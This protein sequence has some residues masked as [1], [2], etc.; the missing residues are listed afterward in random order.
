MPGR[1]VREAVVLAAGEGTR[2]R[3]LTYGRPKVLIPTANRAFL[4]HQLDLL[5]DVGINR[6]VLVVGYMK[7]MVAEW[8]SRN[9]RDGLEIIL[10]IQKEQRGTGDAVNAARG[11]VEGPFLALNGDVL[12]DR[13][14]LRK[15][16]RAECTSVAA[17][18]VANPRDYGVFE[19]EGR[20]VRRVVEKAENPPSDL[21]NVG[22]YVF[23]PDIFDRIDRTPPN[24]KRNEIEIT[25]TLQG[26]IDDGLPVRWFEVA[27]WHELGKTWD[28]IVLNELF[29]DELAKIAATPG[30]RSVGRQVYTGP[31]T[32]IDPRAK[33]IG[34]SVLGTGCRIL[35]DCVIGPHSAVGEGC[36]LSGCVVQGSV[37]MEECTIEE[38]ARVLY[39]VLGRGCRIGKNAVLEDRD[40]TGRTVEVSIKG[41]RFDTGRTRLGPVLGDQ[42]TIGAGATVRAGTL[43]AP[44]THIGTGTMVERN[45]EGAQQ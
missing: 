8:V 17:K 36:I 4:A 3:P 11:S 37:I 35:G 44:R 45:A 18:R 19:V 6:V 22:S 42:S 10:R 27:H 1:R 41:R 33:L 38:G 28:V 20:H 16:V 23:E 7:E 5:A 29:L 39:A 13:D 12:L 2:L 25:D 40:K 34:P 9:A 43:M 26:I 24:P 21:A 31:H 32:V 30:L 14:G 15:M